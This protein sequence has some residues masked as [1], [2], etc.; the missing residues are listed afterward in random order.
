MTAGRSGWIA[1]LFTVGNVAFGLAAL[2]FIFQEVPVLAGFMVLLA[3]GC[4]G[5][6]GLAARRWG[7]RHSR[8]QVW[9]SVA[10]S[11]SFALVPGVLT[12]TTFRAQEQR[13]L[14]TPEAIVAA[15]V[16]GLVAA[17]G[18]LRLVRFSRSG[19]RAGHFVGLPT[20]ASTLLILLTLLLFGPMQGML[21]FGYGLS[22]AVALAFATAAALLGIS[23]L[24]YPKPR[25]RFG[26]VLIGII[27]IGLVATTIYW[28]GW[29]TLEAYLTVTRLG[30]WTGL[31]AV[32]LYV[33]G[34]PVYA[35]KAGGEGGTL[36]PLQRVG[37]SGL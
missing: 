35:Q 26:Q 11:L 13:F 15:A 4:D 3:M 7:S 37:E 31:G 36:V 24:P 21:A 10:D 25:G 20:P 32:L 17:C 9:D 27:G 6:D 18:I 8:G 19:Y 30:A 16:G 14:E 12:Y 23:G 22:P 28:V 2:W 29:G 34:G 33:I 5:L 1:D